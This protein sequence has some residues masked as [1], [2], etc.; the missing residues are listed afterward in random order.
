LRTGVAAF[1]SWG[2]VHLNPAKLQSR[3]RW[4]Y[5][6]AIR[7]DATY[8]IGFNTRGLA[9]Q[10][11][12]QIDRAIE[13]YDEAIRLNPISAVAFDNRA[14]ARQITGQERQS[15]RDN[16]CLAAASRADAYRNQAQWE[17]AQ[18]EFA[19]I[20]P[21]GL[22][23][24]RDCDDG[25]R[26]SQCR[27]VPQ[28]RFPSYERP[29]VRSCDTDFDEAIRV[30]PTAAAAS[31]GRA[32]ALRFVEQYDRAVA[33]YRKALTLQL[34]E[35]SQSQVGKALKQLGAAAAQGV[36]NVSKRWFLN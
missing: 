16:R 21:T 36:A 2:N 31:S 6:A 5:N 24:V 32:H 14:T 7:L 4:D 28:S 27:R 20:W 13:D 15:D 18:W 3:H 34:D 29:A 10:R 12:R 33:D 17:F 1:N 19:P 22:W 25:W 11:K 35:R 23:G 8:E 30:D 9:S 26:L